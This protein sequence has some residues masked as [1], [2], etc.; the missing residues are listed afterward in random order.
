MNDK[1]NDN[2]QTQ[3]ANNQ[4]QQSG[5]SSSNSTQSTPPPPRPQLPAEAHEWRAMK[6][7]VNFRAIK[8]VF[9]ERNNSNTKTTSE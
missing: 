1:K 3:T 5:A 7:E 6:S 2:P 8:E 9:S 4:N